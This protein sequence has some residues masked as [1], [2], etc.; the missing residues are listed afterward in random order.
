M[1]IKINTATN[2]KYIAPKR[3]LK[4][5]VALHTVPHMTCTESTVRN[6]E[7]TSLS[8]VFNFCRSHEAHMTSQ[9][10]FYVRN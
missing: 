9:F 5:H 3:T 2:N 10:G 7:V 1:K 8:Q 4:V 6:E